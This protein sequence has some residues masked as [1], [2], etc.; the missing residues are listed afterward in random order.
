MNATHSDERKFL[1][2]VNDNRNRILKV[3]RVYAWNAA[4]RDDLFGAYRSWFEPQSNLSPLVLT[5]FLRR[6]DDDTCWERFDEEHVERAYD[7]DEVEATL[8]EAGLQVIEIR[9]FHD[10]SGTLGG[11][12]SEESERVVYFAHRPVVSA[13]PA[14]RPR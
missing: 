12:G 5:F 10:G 9:S 13:E 6:E 14:P 2:L 1:E 4:D 3:C 7:L 11:H 8:S